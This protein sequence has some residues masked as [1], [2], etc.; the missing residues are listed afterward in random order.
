MTGI[1]DNHVMVVP[2][3][4]IGIVWYLY[5]PHTLKFSSYS[6]SYFQFHVI[7]TFNDFTAQHMSKQSCMPNVSL[8]YIPLL[9][10]VMFPHIV[11]V[12]LLVVEPITIAP[13]DMKLDVWTD[14]GDS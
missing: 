7:L 12:L 5:S 4:I 13:T 1:H 3:I 8:K 10:K 9:V 6:S 2:C 11:H 14:F